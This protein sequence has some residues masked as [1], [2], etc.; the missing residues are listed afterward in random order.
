M[1][2]ISSDL[3]QEL[4]DNTYELLG[5]ISDLRKYERYDS[6]CR[7]YERDIAALKAALEKEEAA[8]TST[9]ISVMPCLQEQCIN[10]P[11]GCSQCCHLE[12]PSLSEART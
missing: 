1:V 2:E 9:N 7:C 3:A 10:F 8:S 4:L 12:R 6:R 5:T 11:N